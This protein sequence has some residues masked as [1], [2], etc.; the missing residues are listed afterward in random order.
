MRLQISLEGSDQDI[1]AIADAFARFHG[2]QDTV[3]IANDDVDNPVSK[4]DHM[5]QKIRDIVLKDASTYRIRQAQDEAVKAQREAT[6]V[7]MDGVTITAKRSDEPSLPQ[8]TS[9]D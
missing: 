7:L 1:D 9:R 2:W 6:S 5:A 8:E 4:L 3:C